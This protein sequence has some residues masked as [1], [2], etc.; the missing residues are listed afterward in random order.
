MIRGFD[1]NAPLVCEGIIGDGC[2]GGRIFYIE[3]EK[4]YVYDPISKENIVLANGI[5]EAISLSKSGCLLFIQ[6]K[7]KELRY[8]ISALEFI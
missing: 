3:D 1:V 4:L 6:C 2:G 8:D 7:E 5:K